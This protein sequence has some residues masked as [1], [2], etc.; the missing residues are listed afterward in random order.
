MRCVQSDVSAVNG[1]VPG[2]VHDA[3]HGRKDGGK[4]GRRDKAECDD[5]SKES[6]NTAHSEGFL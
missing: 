5:G 3:L 2:I 1:T 6:G 4:G